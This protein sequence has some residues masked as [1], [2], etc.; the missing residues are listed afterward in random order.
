MQKHCVFACFLNTRLGQETKKTAWQP[1][2]KNIKNHLKIQAFWDEISIILGIG[3]RMWNVAVLRTV[4]ASIS[5]SVLEHLG[6][7]NPLK[8]ILKGICKRPS[9]QPS[10]K[11]ENC[12][13]QPPVN[14]CSKGPESTTIRRHAFCK[15]FSKQ[16]SKQA[17][18][19]ASKQA[20]KSTSGQTSIEA[21]W[22][23]KK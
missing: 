22:Q 12:S 2:Q 11:R 5:A 4:L 3:L 8:T 6:P 17:S 16:K 7:Q 19:Q 14:L 9:Q 15:H 13:N 20:K 23:T 10:K 18:M 1:L 21:C